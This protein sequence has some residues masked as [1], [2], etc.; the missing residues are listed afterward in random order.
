[1][2][3]IMDNPNMAVR[4]GAAGRRAIRAS[5]DWTA[6]ARHLEEALLGLIEGRTPPTQRSGVVV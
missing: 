2:G 5:H 4:L 1:V 3:E 6:I